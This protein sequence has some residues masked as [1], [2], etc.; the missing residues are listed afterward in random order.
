MYID[1]GCLVELRWLKTSG[2]MEVRERVKRWC[3]VDLERAR[4]DLERIWSG[5]GEDVGHRWN[6]REE[7]SQKKV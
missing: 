5:S 6:E 1:N 3:R 2:V 7:G 4:A